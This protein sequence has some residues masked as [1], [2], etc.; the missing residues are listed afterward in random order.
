MDLRQRIVAALEEDLG[1][2]DLTTEA[3][4]PAEARTRATVMAK[5]PLVV[6]GNRFAATV[7]DVVGE[8]LGLGAVSYTVLVEDGTAVEDRTRVARVEGP[9]RSVLVG[10]R[11]ALNLMMRACGI[12]TH[13][14]DVLVQAGD[15]RFRVVDTRKTT[16]LWRDL[17]KHSVRCGG[18]RNHRFGLFD[19]V[20]I[21]D[22]HISAV[23]SVA[24]A[25][26]R[27]H[28]SAHHLVKVEVEVS[29]LEQLQAAIAA[30]ADALLLD[31]MDD[32]QLAAAV[33]RARALDPRVFLEASG[34]MN[35]ERLA[36]IG[37]LDLDAVSMGGLIH[38]ARWADLSMKVDP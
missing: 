34:N 23:G 11:M 28:A 6:A 19:G 7:F 22:N 24:E 29:T 10:E 37:S 35:A 30:G 38:Q 2:G 16:P 21:K 36:R 12:A 9:A 14:R 15:V 1:P 13:V 4:I 8:A 26:A 18:G 27:A 25:V 3:C 31:N 17:E 20:L 33:G 32:A 5:Q